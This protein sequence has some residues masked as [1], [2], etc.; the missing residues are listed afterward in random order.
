MCWSRF[1]LSLRSTS[2]V[3]SSCQQLKSVL[4]EGIVQC[5]KEAC[6]VG[7]NVINYVVGVCE[8]RKCEDVQN[9][10]YTTDKGGWDVYVLGDNVSLSEDVSA[11][12]TKYNQLHII[13]PAVVVP[14]VLGILIIGTLVYV[15]RI[16]HSNPRGMTRADDPP[17]VEYS[18]TNVKPCTKEDNPASAEGPDV[19]V[20]D[21]IPDEA[22]YE[23]LSDQA[24]DH[25]ME[26]Y[27]T[28]KNIQL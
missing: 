20:Y 6:N 10:E 2:K 5:A 13:V 9:T 27:T 28:V 11:Q 18:K 4:N 22:P 17:N 25:Y 15:S 1:N 14:V 19:D 26:P 16:R 23:Q 12:D 3:S 24:R 8:L 7:A 21:V